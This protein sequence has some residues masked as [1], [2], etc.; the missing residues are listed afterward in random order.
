MDLARTFFTNYA[1]LC[2]SI[3]SFCL[4]LFIYGNTFSPYNNTRNS[5]VSIYIN[6]NSHWSN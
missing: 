6:M 4:R 5:G 3:G 1:I 2:K